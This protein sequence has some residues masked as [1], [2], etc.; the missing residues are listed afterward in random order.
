MY[1]D[2]FGLVCATSAGRRQAPP[3]K[4]KHCHQI[5]ASCAI[6]AAASGYAAFGPG[7][8]L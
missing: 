5:H 2:G 7:H 3:G 1:F 6:R 8:E 4:S